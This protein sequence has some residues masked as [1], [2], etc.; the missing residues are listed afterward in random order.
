MMLIDVFIL[1]ILLGGF[2]LV[3]NQVAY[4]IQIKCAERISELA[5]QRIAEGEPW[6]DL[7]KKYE[8]LSYNQIMFNLTVWTPAQARPWLFDK[9]TSTSTRKEQS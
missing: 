3:R 2:L 8:E 7:Y 1:A 6:M 9:V 5:M 4:R